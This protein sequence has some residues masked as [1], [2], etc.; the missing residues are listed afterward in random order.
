MKIKSPTAMNLTCQNCVSYQLV[1]HL[2]H[3]LYI[4]EGVPVTVSHKL[5]MSFAV[6]GSNISPLKL[7]W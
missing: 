7:G 3:P 2:A 4:L 6:T 5:K 1:W